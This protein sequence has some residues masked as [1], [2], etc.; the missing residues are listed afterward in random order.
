M[1]DEIKKKILIVDDDEFLLDMY[2]IKF[3]ESG[4]EIEV[5]ISGPS[6]LDK[7]K[8]GFSPDIILLDIVMPGMDGFEFLKQLKKENLA[9]SAEVVILTNLGQKEDVQKGLAM[10]AKD[11]VIKAHHTP[12]EIVAKVKSI[13]SNL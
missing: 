8:N 13:L 11:Y 4:F 6:A 3:R 10:G 1:T 2:A 12:S 5:T 7:I 9:P